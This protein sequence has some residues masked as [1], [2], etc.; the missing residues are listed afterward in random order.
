[1]K[2]TIED[3]KLYLINN[4]KNFIVLSET[5]KNCKEKLIFKCK[6]CGH[7]WEASFDSISNGGTGCPQCA[8]NIKGRNKA[9]R[10]EDVIEKIKKTNPNITVLTKTYKNR[11]EVVKCKCSIDGYEWETKWCN[12]IAGH[13]CHMCSTNKLKLNFSYTLDEI[14]DKLKIINPNIIITSDRYENNTTRVSCKCLIDGYEWK[15]TV[16]NLIKRKNPTSCPKC[17]GSIPWT[18]EELNKLQDGIL[19]LDIFNKKSGKRN[20]KFLK[21][22]CKIHNHE[23]ECEVSSFTRGVSCPICGLRKGESNGCWKGGITPISNHLRGL[24]SKWVKDSLK[25]GKYKCDITGSKENL[26]VHHTYSFNLIVQETFE[27]LGLEILSE[28]N[29]YSEDDLIKIENVFMKIHNKYGLGVCLNEGIHEE[30]HKQYGYGN[31][32]PEQYLEFKNIS[33]I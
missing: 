17:K 22:F 27:M 18:I 21:C 14:K 7:E 26:E 16:G 29:K 10:Y 19:V 23:W 3:I 31:N 8:Q 30:F 11:N 32:T 9:L 5:Y 20:R 33:Y 24:T 1:M 25:Y 12:L 2:K 13:G 4:D 28:V 15:T 6:T